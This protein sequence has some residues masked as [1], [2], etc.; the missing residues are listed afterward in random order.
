MLE[1]SLTAGIIGSR[2]REAAAC[3]CYVANRT[4]GHCMSAIAPKW[5]C[6]SLDKTLRDELISGS[7]SAA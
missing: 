3:L 4:G 2:P 6:Q 7:T 5:T 1:V